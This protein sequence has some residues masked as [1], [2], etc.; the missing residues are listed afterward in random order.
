MSHLHQIRVGHA[1]DGRVWGDGA[2]VLVDRLWPRGLSKARADLDEWCKTVAP[3]VELR[4]WYGHDP[5]L[6]E[7]FRERYRTELDEPE[8]IEALRHLQALAKRRKLTLLTAA[9][10]LETSHAIVLVDLLGEHG[11]TG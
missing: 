2:R 10:R 8:R 4:T 3:S 7:Q 6:F 5:E 9:T 1:Y 11:D